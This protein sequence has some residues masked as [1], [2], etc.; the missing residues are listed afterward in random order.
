MTIETLENQMER[1]NLRYPEATCESIDHGAFLIKVPHIKLSEGWKAYK[2]IHVTKA[3][4]GGGHLM[5][6]GPPRV[7]LHCTELSDTPDEAL[8]MFVLPPGYPW[9]D[10]ENFWTW[11]EL[12]TPTGNWPKYYNSSNRIPGASNQD[13]GSWFKWKIL[14]GSSVSIFQ[15]IHVIKQRLSLP[16]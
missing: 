5:F 16:Y 12:R 3:M 8:V 14:A 9:V 11:E 4:T 10:P 15:Y 13:I 7:H 1:V 2:N 6:M